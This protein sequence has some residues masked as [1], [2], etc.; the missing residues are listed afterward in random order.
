MFLHVPATEKFAAKVKDLPANLLNLVHIESAL[1]CDKFWF[2][3]KTIDYSRKWF[4][5]KVFFFVFAIRF[6]Y[7]I[8]SWRIAPQLL[9]IPSKVMIFW[10]L[11]FFLKTE[12]TVDRIL[13]NHVF[14]YRLEFEL[15]NILFCK[16]GMNI[17]V[18]NTQNGGER[19]KCK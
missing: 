6:V 15:V 2:F 5:Q 1:K 4:R 10:N 12:N 16:I 17:H 8:K 19:K 13:F 11:P 9:I 7:E 3:S 18:Q 14:Y